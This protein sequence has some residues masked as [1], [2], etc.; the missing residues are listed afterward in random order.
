MPIAT[1]EG[2]KF[3]SLKRVRKLQGE[4]EK[5][6]K[7]MG[8]AFEKRTY[9]ST[10]YFGLSMNDPD[11]VI[12]I[13][14]PQLFFAMKPDEYVKLHEEVLGYPP[15]NSEL[16]TAP[17]VSARVKQIIRQA[18]RSVEN[19]IQAINK[20]ESH[21]DEEKAITAEQAKRMVAQ[22]LT[23]YTANLPGRSS[24]PKFKPKKKA[25]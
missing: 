19:T 14:A 1:E 4:A 17:G 5:E 13:D 18:R 12:G 11:Q 3:I 22:A 20:S 16:E 8:F 25:K 9:S 10:V 21:P 6:G 15:T 23:E 24:K 2:I 7:P